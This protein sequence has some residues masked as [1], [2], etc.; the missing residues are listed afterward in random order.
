MPWDPSLLS[1]EE[2]AARAAREGS[3]GPAFMSLVDRYQ[4]R[5]WRMC[6]GLMGDAVDAEDAAQEVFVRLFFQRH[7]FEGRSKF[8]TWVYSI[9]LRTCQQQRRSRGRRERRETEAGRA[10]ARRERDTDVQAAQ[11]AG[12]DVLHMLDCLEEDDRALM[13]LKY[14]EGRGYDELSELFGI[15][16]SACKMRISRA[17]EKLKERYPEHDFSG[18]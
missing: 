15:S 7:K 1:D 14:A 11:D 16:E 18:D 6:F 12:L 2:L 8:S 5:V 9:A 13:F 4:E 10:E 17:R 3:D